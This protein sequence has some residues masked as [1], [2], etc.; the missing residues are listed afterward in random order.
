LNR[1]NIN[2]KKAS[3]SLA[4]LNAKGAK[5]LSDDDH[6]EVIEDHSRSEEEILVPVKETPKIAVKKIESVESYDDREAIEAVRVKNLELRAKEEEI[7]RQRVVLES[8]KRRN[9][10]AWAAKEAEQREKES[11]I[12]SQEMQLKKKQLEEDLAKEIAKNK[13]LLK[14]QEES[15]NRFSFLNRK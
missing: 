6:P 1:K 8:E 5:H 14:L 4:T 13:E 11:L 10:E 12:Y 9:E 3:I 7:D 15:V 2:Q